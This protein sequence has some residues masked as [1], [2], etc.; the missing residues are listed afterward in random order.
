MRNSQN[1]TGCFLRV[2]TTLV[3]V[4][5]CG[6][7]ATNSQ[8][9]EFDSGFYWGTTS[10]L[11]SSLSAADLYERATVAG[12]ARPDRSL[13]ICTI[14]A[15]HIKL[16]FTSA[17][18]GRV[19]PDPNW[20]KDCEIRHSGGLGG[21]IPVPS[22]NGYSPFLLLLYPD[23]KG[24]SQWAIYLVVPN[25]RGHLTVED[26]RKFLEGSNHEAGLRV[27]EFAICYPLSQRDENPPGAE[28]TERFTK[29]GVGLYVIRSQF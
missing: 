17:Q 27:T 7:C 19:F 24:S 18:I 1:R 10:G 20:L 3:L 21:A 13:A 4:G 2:L 22:P 16:G 14:F 6:G 9:R 26:V 11:N 25:D 29:R 12:A 15:S 23:R 5:V 8:D 28:C